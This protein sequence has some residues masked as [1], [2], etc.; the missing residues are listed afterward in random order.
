[1]KN[2]SELIYFA[3]NLILYLQ[4]NGI[5][6]NNKG[7]PILEEEMFLN[8]IPEIMI[9]YDMR[10]S[11]FVVDKKKTLLCL[12]CADYRIYPRLEKVFL[13]LNVYRE[14]MG[15]VMS[16]ITVTRDMDLEWQNLIMLVNQLYMAV[17]AVNGI[18]VVPNLR[19]GSYETNA[20]F[21]SIPKNILWA[22]SFLGCK[23]DSKYDLK[24]ITSVMNIMPSSLLLY[25]KKDPIAENKLN[26]VGISYK[27]FYDY[28]RLCKK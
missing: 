24:F 25:G 9:P 19:I 7:F 2:L 13:E 27:Y 26:T 6:F 20:N 4:S 14:Y 3:D 15:M 23:K 12:Y 22:T 1:M 5:S 18:K 21:S 28:H 17:L 10:N 11:K 16:D 8:E